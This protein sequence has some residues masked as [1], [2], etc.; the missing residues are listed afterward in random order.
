[1]TSYKTVYANQREFI[2]P[3]PVRGDVGVGYLDTTRTGSGGETRT[4]SNGETRTGTTAGYSFIVQD[5]GKRDFT[6]QVD[7]IEVA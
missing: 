3:A 2:A 4:G 5:V 1:M 7:K 6:V